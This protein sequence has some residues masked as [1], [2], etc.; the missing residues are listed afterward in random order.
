MQIFHLMGL[1]FVLAL[2]SCTSGPTPTPEPTATPEVSQQASPDLL[3]NGGESTP[4]APWVQDRVRALEGIYPFTP[5]GREWLESYDLRQMVGQP[6]WFGSYGHDAWAGVGQAIP[7]KVLHELSHS[8]YGAFSVTGRPDLSWDAPS[9]N[10]PSPAL[11]QYREDLKTFMVQPPDRYEPL[12]DRFR[13]LPNLSRLEDPDL[14]HFGE[15]DLVYMVGGNLDLVPPLT[16]RYFDQFLQSGEFQTWEEAIG[17]YLGLSKDDI[18]LA[19]GYFGLAHFPLV[20]YKGLRSKERTRVASEVR[21]ILEDEERQRLKD[22][23]HQYELIKEK[24]FGDLDEAS[25]EG[26]FKFWRGLLQEMLELHRKHPETL[27][28]EAGPQGTQLAA[29]FDTFLE[30]ERLPQEEQVRL[31]QKA[32]ETP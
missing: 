27:A 22:F 21:S 2:A 9:S 23:A 19:E 6:G 8:Y 24:E 12:R 1:A 14:F 11:R 5:A 17:W 13:N 28:R 29:A 4:R 20:G 15:A 18:R 16:R 10:E 25:F 30:A 32:L 7:V 26:T 31:F 3:V